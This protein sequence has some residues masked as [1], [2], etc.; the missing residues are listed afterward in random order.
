MENK[1]TCKA[2]VMSVT[3]CLLNKLEEQNLVQFLPEYSF[4]KGCKLTFLNE[5]EAFE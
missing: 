2:I 1:V 4:L 3:P 5:L